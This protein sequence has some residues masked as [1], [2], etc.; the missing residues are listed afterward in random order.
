MKTINEVLTNYSEYSTF[1]EDR[2]GSRLCEFLTNEQV[3]KIGFKFKEDYVH[4]PKD[5]TKENI[6]EQLKSDVEFGWSKCQEE[7]GIS[8]ELMS[9]V[10]KSWC[11]V[12]ENG[13]EN[14]PYGWYGDK[15]FKAVDREYG[16][17]ITNQ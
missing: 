11:K 6:L 1:L 3:E 5:W 8:A 15:I 2:F 16:F 14:T 9:E 7:R 4:E 17:E 10:V 12:L 13:L